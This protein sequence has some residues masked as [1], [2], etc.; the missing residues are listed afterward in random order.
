LTV[1]CDLALL[2]SSTL[3][4]TPHARRGEQR[5]LVFTLSVA[6]HPGAANK[7]NAVLKGKGL[8]RC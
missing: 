1:T 7:V 6:P 4:A 8:M 2:Q 3:S 5:V